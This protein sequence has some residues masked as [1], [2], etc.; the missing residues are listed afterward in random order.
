ME[1]P[2]YRAANETSSLGERLGTLHRHGNSSAA[3]IPLA[4]SCRVAEG[5][6][7]RPGPILL[8]AFGAGTLWGS[9]IWRL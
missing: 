8:S 7:L 6:P 2:E 1:L 3:T 5:G 4:L 9:L